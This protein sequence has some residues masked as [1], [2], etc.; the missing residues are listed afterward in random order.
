MSDAAKTETAEPDALPTGK[1]ERNKR[2]NRDMILKA[3]RQVFTDLGFDATTVRDIV[4]QT[5][6]A[7]GTFYNYFR[8]KE[9]VFEAVLDD[10]ALNIRP[11]LHEIRIQARTFEDFIEG[12]FRAFFEHVASDR[13][14]FEMVQRNAGCLR[15]RLESPEVVAG[16]KELR[17]DID[18]AIAQGVAP[19]TDADY[20]TAAIVGLAFELADRMMR[21]EPV[22]VGPAVAFAT[23]LVLGGVAALP[24]VPASGPSVLRAAG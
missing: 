11:R 17:A 1:R 19:A 6:L 14:M 16:L 18:H 15:L 10:T 5:G 24:Q 12:T 23:A 13:E 3:A 8:S 20:L 22:A 7:S 4:R 21:R 9:E 2:E